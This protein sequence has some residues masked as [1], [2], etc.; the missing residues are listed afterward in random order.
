[1]KDFFRQISPKR[2]VKDFATEWNAPNPHRWRFLALAMAMTTSIFLFLI[3]DSARVPPERPE[4]IYISTFDEARTQA[5][6][7][8]S[9][10][11]NQQLKDELE[12]R[13][14]EREEYRR[15]MFRA[16][17]RATFVDVEEIDRQI[18]EDR[19]AEAANAPEPEPLPEGAMTVEEYCAQAAAG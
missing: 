13:I 18:A 8:A 12:A 14:A 7:I 5:Q 2:A 11:A 4:V 19:A 15:E 3:P 16:L 10:C 1:M 17:G 6:I 9:N